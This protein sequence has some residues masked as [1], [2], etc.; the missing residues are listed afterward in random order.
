[1]PVSYF[2]MLQKQEWCMDRWCSKVTKCRAWKESLCVLTHNSFNVSACLI[3]LLKYSF[4]PVVLEKTLE[5]PLDFKEIKPVNPKGNQPWIFS[6]D[7]EAEAPMLW[8]PDAKS[9][10]TGKDDDAGKDWRQKEKRAAGDKM[11]GWHHWLNRH[12]FEQT[13]GDSEE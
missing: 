6:T 2:E 4:W 13:P 1:M 9:W 12:E 10:L 11:V 5:S 3:F 7:A 8:S